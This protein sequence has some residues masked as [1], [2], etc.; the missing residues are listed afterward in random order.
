MWI[1]GKKGFAL[2][3]AFVVV[4]ASFTIAW[5]IYRWDLGITLMVDTDKGEYG[6]GEPVRIQ[7]QLK[8]HGF[9]TVNLVY[10]TSITLGM[11]ISDSDGN[12]V[13]QAPRMALEVIT[14][15]ALKPGGTLNWG[16]TWDQVNDTGEPVG[17]GTF[18]VHAFSPSSKHFYQ[19]ESKFSISR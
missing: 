16:Y 13:I 4:A 7:L 5:V 15:V 12:R 11:V 9:S 3:A 14:K 6:A 2:A 17:P 1:C 8:N 18:T 10:G 19:T